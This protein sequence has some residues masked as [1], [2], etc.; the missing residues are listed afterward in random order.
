MGFNKK[1]FSIVIIFFA[2]FYKNMSFLKTL[3]QVLGI[4]SFIEQPPYE[5]VEKLD[6]NVE[7]RKY[8]PSKW[9]CT[10]VKTDAKDMQSYSNP[11][12]GTLFRYISGNNEANQKIA[13]TS[14]VT[15]DMK[16]KDSDLIENQ[17]KVEVAMRFY[18]PK[19]FQEKTP[20]PTNDAYLTEDPE[21]TVAVITFGGYASMN[22]YYKHRDL[23]IEKL[24][25]EASKYDCVNMMLAGYDPPFK[26]IGR[27]N[28]VWLKKI[29][30]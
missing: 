24:G 5:V 26:P 17:S 12:F 28:E 7:I 16:N 30:N 10:K 3:G 15:F 21:M 8:A 18:V 22:D 13:M 29:I 25:N 4:S 1:L 9:V 27:T 11:M 20:L 23:L 2:V 6:I 14:P 19:E